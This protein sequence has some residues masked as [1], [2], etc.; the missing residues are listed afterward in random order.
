MSGDTPPSE[1]RNFKHAIA[2]EI[3]IAYRQAAM[4]RR[5]T[6]SRDIH[7]GL[8]AMRHGFE[9]ILQRL[10]PLSDQHEK[11]WEEIRTQF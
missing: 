6:K 4:L 3:F 11:I 2:E 10:F 1:V 7:E 8:D 5:T 9:L